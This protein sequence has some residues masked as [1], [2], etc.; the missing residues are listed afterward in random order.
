MKINKEILNWIYELCFIHGV[1]ITQGIKPTSM[2]EII[3]HLKKEAGV[4]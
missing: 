4:I 2:N 1:L 3:E